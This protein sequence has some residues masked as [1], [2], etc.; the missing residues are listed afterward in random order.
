[1]GGHGYV[2]GD[3]VAIRGST[4]ANVDG[5]HKVTAVVA[6]V[7]FDTDVTYVASG[8][9][10]DVSAV[11]G[12]FASM[13][14]DAWL[15]RGGVSTDVAEAGFVTT[16]QF[17][18]EG[19]KHSIHYIESIR[20]VRVATAIRDGYWH[21]YEGVW[22]TDPTAAQDSFG[23]DDAARPSYA[24]PGELTYRTSGQPD[25]SGGGVT[26]DDYEA[27]TGG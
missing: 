9:A 7:T 14:A 16:N 2:V 6:G 11:T 5:I 19:V 18:N 13:T 15:M 1:L 10:G 22:T 3:V 17:G 26:S 20:T 4:S 25:G 23:Q 21:I 24:I 8:T 27:K 12:R